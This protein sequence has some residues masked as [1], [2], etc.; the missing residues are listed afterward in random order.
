[1]KKL[2]LLTLSAGLLLTG[3]YNDDFD[4]VDGDINELRALLAQSDINNAALVA[5]L[6]DRVDAADA[7]I[8]AAQAEINEDTEADIAAA[9]VLADETSDLLAAAQAELARL[10][11]LVNGQNSVDG[12]L[13]RAIAALQ[14]S[15]GTLSSDLEDLEDDLGDLEDEVDD[16]DVD[17][18]AITWTPSFSTQTA[19]FT[20][21][22]TS[23]SGTT[24]RVIAIGTTTSTITVTQLE[25][26]YGSLAAHDINNDG[27]H[28]DQIRATRVDTTYTGT[29]SGT[30]TVVGTHYVT[31]T[32]SPYIVIDDN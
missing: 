12:A 31:V 17:L 25:H 8:V 18:N 19:A 6:A 26:Q 30:T 4:R 32:L 23:L 10:T 28:A 16:I 13:A 2:L 3:C 15:V 7:A 14:T 5:A 1:M 20:Q 22:G 9:N 29:V 27:D 11:A 21:V 24:S